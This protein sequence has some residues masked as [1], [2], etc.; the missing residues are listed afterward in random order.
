MKSMTLAWRSFSVFGVLAVLV[1]GGCSEERSQW[2]D[3]SSGTEPTEPYEDWIDK[4]T[5]EYS[6]RRVGTIRSGSHEYIVFDYHYILLAACSTCANRGGQRV[7][8]FE[9]DRY[10][11]QYKP[12]DVD[13]YI[14]DGR[15]FF[16]PISERQDD[17]AELKMTEHG[18][19]PELLVN[20]ELLDFF[21]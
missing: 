21:R 9:D 16:R 17:V 12:Y 14:T 6:V 13:V 10:V 4:H 19:P 20:G 5:N 8:F 15:L 7:L 11:G 3:T 18:F 2:F 1:L